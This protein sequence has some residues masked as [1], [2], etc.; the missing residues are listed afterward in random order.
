MSS[1]VSAKVGD[2]SEHVTVGFV[3]SMAALFVQEGVP[4][5]R[6]QNVEPY[7]L[8]MEGLKFIS[9]ET[10]AKWKKSA[11]TPGDVV[12]VR[13][14]YPGTAAVVPEGIGPLNAASLVIV[15]P[16]KKKLDPR[17]LAYVFNSPWGV[18]EISGRL[19]GSAQQ[20]LNTKTV[21]GLE[22]PAPPI[23][24]QRRIA[25]ILGAYDDLIEINRRRVA[26]LEEM[27]RGLFEEWFVRFRFPGHEEVPIVDTPDGPL[28][29]GWEWINLYEAA[30]VAFG[31]AFKSKAFTTEPLGARVVRIRDVL[32]GRTSTWTQ[33]EFDDRYQVRN[34]DLLVG[35]DG[36]FHTNVWVGGDAALNQRV[37]RLR[38]KRDL[39]VGWL[40]QGVLPKIKFFEATIS[41]TTVAHLGAK[42]LKTIALPLADDQ[43][44]RRADAFFA[45]IDDE[46]VNLKLANEKLAASRDLLLPRLISG[47]LSVEAA[48]RELENAA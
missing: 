5:L 34:G 39:S 46:L 3:G 27:A 17:Y 9:P 7:R 48:E 6:G 42:H 45:P 16:D 8:R 10:H 37:T 43:T 12:L 44:Q 28:P 41:G 1:W 21:A 33:E 38:P 31:F 30:D 36:I 23:G 22:I 26:V 29:A 47:Q 18:S 40:F 25:A 4:L 13:V 15:R 14:G 19:V 20:V 32:E 35:M 24:T 2:L 11:L